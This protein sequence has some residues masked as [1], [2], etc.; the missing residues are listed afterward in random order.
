MDSLMVFILLIHNMFC[1][2]AFCPEKSAV[3]NSFRGIEVALEN[4]F[5]DY[6]FFKPKLIPNEVDDFF[7]CLRRPFRSF[8]SLYSLIDR[9]IKGKEFDAV[10]IFNQGIFSFLFLVM[11]LFF[12]VRIKRKVVWVHES[13]SI[14]RLGF[15]RSLS[16]IL[17]DFLSS[18]FVDGVISSAD[19]VSNYIRNVFRKNKITLDLPLSFDF[20][21]LNLK[22]NKNYFDCKKKR[23]LKILFFGFLAKY[24]NLDVLVKVSDYLESKGID[25]EITIIGD[26]NLYENHPLLYKK[27][28][29]S[30]NIFVY[31]EFLD[32]AY[33]AK[34]L[35]DSDILYCYYSSVTATSQ[36]DI[37]NKFGVPVI[38]SNLDFF[39]SKISHGVNGW[40]AENDIDLL[41]IIYGV[42]TFDNKI[43]IDKNNVLYYYLNNK[44]NYCASF[45]RALLGNIF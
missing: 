31:N 9:R 32:A 38:A 26:G 14:K 21:K 36:I 27:S 28:L 25:Y 13:F 39:K 4:E 41:R 45:K 37:A 7:Y 12:R 2:I 40:I 24:K 44:K 3:F 8:L 11:L 6:V 5:K 30:K 17:S 18:Y 43:N 29:S 20:S 33:I 42:A 34:K 15:F 10:L 19:S 35:I 1:I 16:Y 23:C 22:Y